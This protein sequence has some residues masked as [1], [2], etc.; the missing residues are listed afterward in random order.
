MYDF[1][2][3]ICINNDNEKEIQTV[4]E[5][6]QAAADLAED[7]ARPF[8][9]S[10][11][12]KLAALIHDLGKLCIDFNDYILGRNDLKRGMIDH[13]YAGARYL[14]TFA[15][16][17]KNPKLVETAEFISRIV[18]SHH[19]IHDWINEDGEDYFLQRISKDE[20]YSEIET[21]IHSLI[22]DEKLFVLLQAAGKEYEQIR[23]KIYQ[24]STGQAR[25][26]NEKQKLF[27]FYMGQFERLMQSVL[28]DADRTDTAFFQDGMATE[29]DFSK[30]I[31]DKFCENIEK[32]CRE[33][34]KNTDQISKLRSD[35]SKRCRDFSENKRGICR[36]IV[37]TG[38][39][40]TL[41]S[42]RFAVHYCRKHNKER[43]FYIAPY[44]S[45]LD[46]NSEVWKAII[47]EEYLLEHHSDISAEMETDEEIGEYELRSDKWDMPIIAT[48]LIQFLNTLFLERMDSVRRMHRLCNSVIIVDEVQSIPAKCVSLF[49]LAMNFLSEIGESC[50][51]LC[52]ATQPT[53]E[54]TKYPLQIDENQ[55]MT[56][57]YTGDFLAF[58]RNE[59]ISMVRS[60]GYTYDEASDFCLDRYK[61][62]GNILFVVNTKTA[63]YS[64][65]QKVKQRIKDD[66]KVLHISTNMCPEH[67]KTVIK[68]LRE[69]LERHKKVICITT[70]L[71]EAGVD[72]SFPCV[73]RSLAGMDN[74]AQAS[75]RCNRSGEYARCCNVYLMNL[76]E[77]RLGNLKDIKTGQNI[78][79]Q[80]IESGR[81]VD[82][83]SVETM[84]DYFVKYYQEQKEELEYNIEDIG[85]QTDLLE[86]LSVNS[87]RGSLEM[88]RNRKFYTGQAFRTAGEKFHMI[89][90]CS[91]AVAVPY[92]EEARKMIS[93]LRS[94]IRIDE[95][96]KIMRKMQKYMVGIYENTEKKLKNERALERLGCSIYVLDERYYDMEAGIVTEGKPMDFLM[97]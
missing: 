57:D 3:H 34:E 78:S 21:N 33:F 38:G 1:A 50:I 20:R 65:Y 5:H 74:A 15:E 62:E 94:N 42:L 25:I 71:I 81:Y 44:R 22:P 23:G 40:K 32:R 60:S 2:A 27:A 80:M 11:I 85:I 43:I 77:E 8:H 92:N 55:S 83:M 46:Q 90:D 52:S 89:D 14:R 59:M 82:L 61:A 6:C 30:D 29:L 9:A 56:G 58:K 97:F 86:L 51:V 93:D 18:I 64:I 69:M 68:E 16:K 35:I 88:N 48:T 76:D 19:G 17:T 7:Y 95:Q 10:S 47:G 66:T 75:G 24:M 39:G 96:M 12:A 54:K 49:N 26:K 45:I 67:R 31:W 37:P 70:Q 63:A 79:W 53:F 72:I 73:I 84:S 28:V 87:K 13:C 36:L 4:N 41:A 91:M